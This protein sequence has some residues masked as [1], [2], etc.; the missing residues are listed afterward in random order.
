MR[1]PLDE[2]SQLAV[3]HGRPRVP[4]AEI[5]R[6]GDRLRHRRTGLQAL[7]VVAAVGIVVSGGLLATGG[8]TGT[9]PPPGPATRLP[10]PAPATQTPSQSPEQTATPSGESESAHPWTT[11][12]A[13]RIEQ[14]LDATLPAVP[15]GTSTVAGAGR[16]WTGLP[17]GEPGPDD[18]PAARI[19]T[20]R[21]AGIDEQQ[22]DQLASWVSPPGEFHARQLVLYPDGDTAA[23]AVAAIRTQAEQ[24][25]PAPVDGIPAELRWSVRPHDLGGE[26]GMVLAGGTYAEG[27]D[28]RVPGRTLLAVLRQGNA[29]VTLLLSDESSAAVEDLTEADA[30]ALVEAATGLVEVLCSFTEAGCPRG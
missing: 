4:A 23:Q 7:A 28:T 11:V 26:E 2:L 22:T 12:I 19:S 16:P 18:D 14:A 29:V 13:A 6:R 20:T 3:G 1:D 8:V 27:S 10:A 17:C 24:C 15:A 21:F 5:R 25:A 30:R 9:G